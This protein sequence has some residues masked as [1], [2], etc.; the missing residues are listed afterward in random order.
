M[1]TYALSD[2]FATF[3]TRLNPRP[4][5]VQTA[6]SE[7]KT[8]SS[9][10]E[11][12]SGDAAVL[13]P[14]C[15]L[16]G[17]YKQ[18]TAIYTINDVDIVVLCELWQPASGGGGQGR[19][20]NRDA[21]FA[22]IAGPLLQDGR[23]R[24]KVRYHGQSM[25]IKMDLSIQ[26]EILPVVFKAGNGDPAKEPFRL[27]RPETQQWEDGYARYHQD[28]LSL[29]NGQADGN[30][31]PMIKV[32][33]HLRSHWR[34]SAVS[35]HLECLLY[36]LPKHLFGGNPADYIANVL[37]HLAAT[38]ADEWYRRRVLTPCGERDIF[39]PSEWRLDDWKAFHS[40]IVPWAAYAE[41]GRTASDRATAVNAWRLLL[42]DDFFP[43]QVSR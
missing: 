22:T 18:D 3:F 25:C 38:T 10:I 20:W 12:A 4:S 11:S 19:A 29:K 13:K 17:S 7:H 8:I 9:L 36:S 24:D 42:G 31:I 23:Y 43:L 37:S 34:R 1:A 32:L 28:W 2:H 16:Q 15:F 35:F 33:K 26:L 14:R 39:V 41:L 30:F 5:F 21:I 40:A 6:A 27:W